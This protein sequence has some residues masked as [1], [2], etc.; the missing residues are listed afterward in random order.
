MQ[1]L[2]W[3][4]PRQMNLRET[5][6]PQPAANEVLIRGVY[7]GIFGSEFGG[8]LGQ[9]SLRRPPL[10]MGHEFSGEIVALGDE[11]TS[12][13]PT[14]AVGQRV[15][16]NPLISPPWSKAALKGRHNLT[17]P[18]NILGIHR[19]GIYAQFI[20]APAQNVYTLPATM[21]LEPAALTEPMACALRAAKL[22]GC[23][24][25]DRVLI[26]GLGPIGLLT[27]QVV[28]A[29]GA[30]QIFATDTDADRRAIGEQFGVQILNPL[31]EDV[32]A[33]IKSATDGEGVEMA[34]DAVG[35]NATRRQ[36]IDAV[37]PGGRVVFTGL[38]EEESPVQ[39][40]YIIR[41]EINIQGSFAY[42]PL[43]FEAA[44]DWL[45]AD[46]LVIDPWILKAPLAEGGAMFDKLLSNPGPVAKILLVS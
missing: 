36:C 1:A 21:S 41:N 33:V 17:L 5:P 45:A 29:F 23:T 3:E 18:R 7:S 39:A 9:N 26:T 46:R 16:V 32:A 11:A 2:V 28:K 42:T 20:T 43:D 22:S 44:F 34:I 24:A 27:L 14:L 19:P 8:Y 38:H 35:A 31:S 10:I 25:T 6:T 37:A 30:R 40:N 15:T 4:G 12:I 13:K